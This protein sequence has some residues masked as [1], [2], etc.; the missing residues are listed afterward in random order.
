MEFEVVNQDSTNRKHSIEQQMERVDV[1][2]KY[3]Q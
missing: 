1:A 2:I 3:S